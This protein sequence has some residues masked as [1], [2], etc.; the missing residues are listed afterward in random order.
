MPFTIFQKYRKI[1]ATEMNDNFYHCFQGDWLPRGG[2][3]LTATTGVYDLGSDVYRWN[4]VYVQNLEITGELP[5]CFNLIDE[6]TLTDT[7]TTIDITGLNGDT[8]E[9]YI[10]QYRITHDNIPA[11]ATQLRL[12]LNE[13]SATNYGYQRLRANGAVIDASR[14]TLQNAMNLALMRTFTSTTYFTSGEI[15]LFSKSGNERVAI[16]DCARGISDDYMEGIRLG[17]SVWD[18]TIDTLTSLQF[19][20]NSGSMATYTNIKVWAKR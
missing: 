9:I 3:S 16:S 7:A 12:G 20:W 11:S 10:I 18:N 17:G 13:D 8:D 6:T 15:I 4:N 19:Y 5:R 2:V 1:D 14:S